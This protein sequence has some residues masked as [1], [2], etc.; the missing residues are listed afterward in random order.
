MTAIALGSI[1]SGI[2]T[3]ERLAL[4]ACQCLQSTANGSETNAV[5]GAE[6]VPTCN[7]QIAKTA[8]NVDRAICVLYLPIDYDQLNA[9]TAKSWM[10]ALDVSQATPHVNL[11]SN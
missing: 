8:D 3:Y 2:N 5:A 7:V 4:W 9:P 6:S 10:A 11:L 1:P